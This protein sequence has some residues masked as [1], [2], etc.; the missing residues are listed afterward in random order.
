M[1]PSILVVDDEPSILTSLGGLLIDEGYE[2]I[3]ANNG[4]EALKII[5]TQAPDLVLL[6]IW[7]PGMDGIEILKELKQT[8]PYMPVVII[9][10]H[11]NIETAVTATKIGAYDLIEKPISFDKLVLTINN[12]LN[13]QR[14]EEENRYLRKKAIE[15]HSIEGGSPS[16]QALRKEIAVAAPTDSWV[17][18][19]GENGTGKELVA[20][21]LYQLSNR[22]DQPFVDVNCAT[23]PPDRI[24]RE[25]FGY[26][27]NV[28]PE[29]PN[30]KRGKFEIG[31]NG[32]LFLDEVGDMDLSSQAR[33][34]RVLQEQ[35]FQRMGGGRTISV[36]IRIIASTNKD[37]PQEISNGNFREDLFHRLNV[38]PIR[39]PSLR[40]RKED[41]P[42]LIDTFL[43]EAAVNARELPKDIRPDAVML[44]CD[45]HWPGNVRELK[46]LIERL[47]ISVEEEAVT[48]DH[49]LASHPFNR[50]RGDELPLSPQNLLLY[51]DLKE[52]RH[53]FEELFLVSKLRENNNNISK[54]AKAIGVGRSYLHKVIKRMSDRSSQ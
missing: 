41:I 33:I 28:F 14:L 19:T 1:F 44:L 5:E 15:K 40:E 9:T 43:K 47:S 11:G 31:N 45:Y 30:R 20:R 37:L 42:I 29:Y 27:K 50:Y 46:N 4:Y 26:E 51:P 34:L 52:A 2:V 49:V 25:L 10:G 17:L 36:N 35:Q 8:H 6:D 32:T 13:F 21:T 12:A 3:T 38:I 23:L 54:T 22:V 53:A 18:V 39:V 24:D 16:I 48:R 7:M